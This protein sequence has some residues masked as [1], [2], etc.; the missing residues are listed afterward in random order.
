MDFDLIDA[1]GTAAIFKDGGKVASLTLP[2]GVRCPL[3]IF[4]DRET[5][6][7]PTD[8]DN[9]SAE[10]RLTI[11]AA[12]ADLP[13]ETRAP[14][15]SKFVAGGKTYVVDDDDAQTTQDAVVATHIVREL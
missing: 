14:P 15:K 2:S 7:A 9:F 8:F 5:L 12:L 10:Q 6:L 11:T 1:A 13:G 3:T 4:I